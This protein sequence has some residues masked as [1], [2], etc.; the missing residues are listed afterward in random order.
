M[1]KSIKINNYSL[2]Q[3]HAGQ[4]I[5]PAAHICRDPDGVW[6]SVVRWDDRSDG[7]IT[8]HHKEHKTQRQAEEAV[9][10]EVRIM[11]DSWS[12]I[13]LSRFVRLKAGL[14]KLGIHIP[15]VTFD[16][17][18]CR[19]CFRG[20]ECSGDVFDAAVANVDSQGYEWDN[21]PKKSERLQ[22]LLSGNV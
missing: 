7:T 6:H 1:M 21:S 22:K 13:D 4:M 15:S 11:S 8:V 3:Y 10:I 5:T 17:V 14:G 16:P 12:T 19:V 18:A 9:M 20:E 2:S